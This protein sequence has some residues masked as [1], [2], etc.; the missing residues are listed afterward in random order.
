MEQKLRP[1]NK[2]ARVCPLDCGNKIAYSTNGAKLDFYLQKNEV[3][4]LPFTLFKTKKLMAQR[5]KF[6]T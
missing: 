1:R 2:I 6:K 3:R 4:F 5:P